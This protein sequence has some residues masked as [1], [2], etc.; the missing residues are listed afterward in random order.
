MRPDTPL[1]EADPADA[2][3][4]QREAA[5]VDDDTDGTGAGF[6][7]ATVTEADPADAAEQDRDAGQDDED[8]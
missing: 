5:P 3:E 2:L 7:P 8:Y 6:P 1:P 4:Q